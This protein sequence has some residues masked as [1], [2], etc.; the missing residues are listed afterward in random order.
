MSAGV[1]QV[2]QAMADYLNRQGVPA[3]V[4]WP[5]RLRQEQKET[6]A[7]VS[8][9]GCQA[10]TAAFQD[11]LGERYDDQTGRWSEWYGRRARLTLG[12]D[13]Y[14]PEGGDGQAVQRAFDALAGALILGGP[15]GLRVEEFS[16]GQTA[17]D[18]DSRRLMRPVQAVCGA[19]LCAAAGDDGAFTDFE[20]RGVIEA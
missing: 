14:A 19:W 16:C 4:A 10:E 6:L 15:E 2:C 18:P 7:V 9:R 13:L 20:L 11:Y 1:E 17:Y 12:L 8:L 3:A 5:A